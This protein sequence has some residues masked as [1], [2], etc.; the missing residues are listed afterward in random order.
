MFLLIKFIW[1][2]LLLTNYRVI[3]EVDSTPVMGYQNFCTTN[4]CTAAV[5][6]GVFV[7]AGSISSV[8]KGGFH[9]APL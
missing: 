7:L 9:V 8:T 6:V 3:E 4:H 2:M 1:K 5:Q